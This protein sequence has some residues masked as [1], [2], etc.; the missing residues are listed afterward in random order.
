MPK[1]ELIQSRVESNIFKVLKESSSQG[2]SQVGGGGH[3]TFRSEHETL[4]TNLTLYL[5]TGICHGAATLMRSRAS[6]QW[7]RQLYR[8]ELDPWALEGNEGNVT[9]TGNTE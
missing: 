8:T 1:K 9:E 7:S 4:L 3:L 5:C 6:G 2:L